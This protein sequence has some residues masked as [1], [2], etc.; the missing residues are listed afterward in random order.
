MTPASVISFARE[1]EPDFPVVYMSGAA[2]A[3]WVSKGVSNSIMLA[4][5]LRPSFSQHRRRPDA[6]QTA[7][8]VSARLTSPTSLGR[9]REGARRALMRPHPRMYTPAGEVRGMAPKHHP[10]PLSGG[11]RKALKKELSKS[12]AM[13]RTFA[14]RSAEKRRE[15]ETLIRE[16]DKELAAI[17]R[18]VRGLGMYRDELPY[19]TRVKCPHT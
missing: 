6:A 14:E 16:A 3:D 10:T 8:A 15:G 13:T 19:R 12:P 18:R 7:K 9:L 5:L 2:A 1:I 17:S 11:D 4:H